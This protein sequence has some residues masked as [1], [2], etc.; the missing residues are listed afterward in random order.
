M[1]CGGRVKTLEA[2]GES[3]ANSDAQ[4]RACQFLLSHQAKDGG[5]GES[6]LSSQDKV[7]HC[8]CVSACEGNAVGAEDWS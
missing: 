1:D 3:V 6:Y 4:R 2:V 8:L 5:W 7:G